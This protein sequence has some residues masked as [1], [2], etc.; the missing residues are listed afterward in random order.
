MDMTD[1][2][3]SLRSQLFAAPVGETHA[4]STKRRGL[5]RVALGIA[6][7][8]A[9]LVALA[10]GAGT[11]YEAVAARGDAAAYPAA[12]RLVDVGGY[13]VHLDCLGEGSP[14]IVLDAGLGGSSLDWGLVQPQLA[15]STRVCSYD[16]AGMGWSDPGPGAR[17][18]AQLAEE[19]HTL[20]TNAGVAGPFVL[21]GHS[22]AG[23][24]L[25]LFA[26]GY[27]SDVAGMVLV[28][29]RSERVDAKLSAT[30]IEGFKGAL[31][32]QATLYTIA[33]R[34]GVARLFGAALLSD[35]PLVAPALAQEMVLLQ[36]QPNAVAETTAEG[37]A[38]SAD[39]DELADATLG[40]MP[41]AVIAARQSMDGIAG[42]P[43]AQRALA[44]LSSKG[45]LVVAETSH[46]IPLERPDIVVDAVLSVLASARARN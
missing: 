37:L 18:P 44:A 7:G 16:R 5:R 2:S 34:L 19:L 31:N 25:R 1:Y 41:L 42:W 27:P 13:R 12:G 38:R 6:G 15:A 14:T 9:G 28:D 4:G 46:A 26:K 20:L 11:V 40:D 10:A 3:P 35:E 36:T 32:G 17:A 24:N 30:E 21:V 39:D 43:E 29:T 23:K 22:L 33:R 8:L 45:S